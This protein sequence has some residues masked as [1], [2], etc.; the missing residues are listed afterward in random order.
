[1][2]TKLHK[3]LLKSKP[4]QRI[5]VRL[6]ATY[7]SLVNATG[8][9]QFDIHPMAQL[10]ITGRANAI[11]AFWHGRMMMMPTAHPKHLP[12][13]VL[14]SLHR[15]G[16]LISDVIAQFDLHTIKGSSSKGGRTAMV[17]L[18]RLLKDGNNVTITPDGP[19]G[20]HQVASQG[21]I[22]AA[23]ISGRPIIPVSFSATRHRRMKSWDRFMVALPFSRIIFC[24][25]APIVI[26]KD[27]EDGLALK[28][29]ESSLNA[30]TE[31][32]DA[33]LL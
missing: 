19:R 26:D 23:K 32:A 14:I 11:F 12:M 33:A 21:I 22:T 8:R 27:M 5:I 7:I 17:E 3:R 28:R 16:M 20:P 9:K 10:F 30:L 4:A 13:H 2:N 25:G 29:V 6:L 1:M 24:V 18:L 15:D 31:K